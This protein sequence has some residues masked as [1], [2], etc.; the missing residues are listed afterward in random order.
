[1][2]S[3]GKL[4]TLKELIFQDV[5]SENETKRTAVILRLFCIVMWLYYLVLLA[6]CLIYGDMLVFQVSIPCSLL[7]LLSFYWTYRDRTKY[8]LWMVNAI[9]LGWI[10][11]I[12]FSLGWDSGVQH[13]LFVLMMSVFMT[14]H[15][16]M[17]FK[18]LYAAVLCFIRLGLY[19][20]TLEYKPEF[21]MKPEIGIAFQFWNTFAICSI[22]IVS[23]AIYS[24]DSMEMEKKLMD[25]N[26]KLKT[27]ASIDP[28]TK[29]GN[30]RN[31]LTYLERK[32]EDYQ[33]GNIS[34]LTIALGDI[35]FF[36]KVN[37]CYGHE[38]GD[39]VLKRVS[40]LM[41][42]KLEGRAKVGRWGGEEFLIILP[43]CNGDEATA[44]LT[45][46]L[47]AIRR[48]KIEYGGEKVC[49]T[50]T[51]GVTEYDSRVKTDEIINEADR[52]L[53]I[54]KESGRNQVVF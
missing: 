13:F 41:K 27:M 22:I 47:S 37:D 14:S 46:L 31:T 34:N 43:E 38:C 7:Y 45:E 44:A 6:V 51:F 11:T 21:M 52:K 26:E 54:G 39:I 50:M 2:K 8:A 32:T 5:K 10:V 49:V 33:K 9:T 18:V 1:M 35:D 53:Y 3:A 12:V 36:K 29:L 25:Y 28:L 42:E 48:T 23:M 16:R 20:Y 17:R 4:Q 15:M 30:R 40:E 24:S 19:L